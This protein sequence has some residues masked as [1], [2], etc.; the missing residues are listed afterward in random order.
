MADDCLTWE[1]HVEYIT[2]KINR[3]IGILKRVRHIVWKDSLMLL[4]Q[5]MIELYFRYCNGVWGQCNEGLKDKLQNLQNRAARTIAK[6]KYDE[7][8]HQTLLSDFGWLS[9]RDLITYDTWVFMY[10]IVHS[11]APGHITDLFCKQEI[12]HRHRTRS[13]ES[14]NIFIHQRNL[15]LG[16]EAIT[17]SG[18]KIWN[19]ISCDIK[20]TQ[21]LDAFKGKLKKFLPCK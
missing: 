13:A 17:F 21:S 8:D 2:G 3:G 5:T 14:G 18:A 11:L 20:R 9:V 16:Q 6:L 19:D 7:A 12:V 4:Y 1:A 10:K 15:K